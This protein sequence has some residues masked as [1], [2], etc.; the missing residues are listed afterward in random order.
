MEENK[1]EKKFKGKK[2]Q[3]EVT[4][5][6]TFV[7]A[8][9]YQPLLGVTISKDTDIDDITEDGTIHQIIKGTNFITEAKKEYETNEIKVKEESRLEM[10][11]PEGTIL[12][13]SP[14]EGYIVPSVPVQTI[15]QIQEDLSLLVDN[16]G[17]TL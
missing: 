9:S 12:V 1:E 13:Y 11:L 4:P 6:E 2:P 10:E 15:K 17:K 7:I 8:P 5:V 16:K 3:G 14:R